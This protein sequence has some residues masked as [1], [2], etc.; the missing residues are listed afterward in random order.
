[1]KKKHFEEIKHKTAADLKKA[2]LETRDKLWQLKVDLRS[3]KVK[4]VKALREARKDI[5]KILTIINQK[6]GK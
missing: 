1:M 5:A 6:H 2:L 4:N 3:G